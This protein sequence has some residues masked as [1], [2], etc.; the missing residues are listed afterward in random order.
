MTSDLVSSRPLRTCRFTA[1]CVWPIL[2]GVILTVAISWGISALGPP[3][4][5]TATVVVRDGGQPLVPASIGKA[6]GQRQ[7]TL[8]SDLSPP[9]ATIGAT[10]DLPHW[11]ARPNVQWDTCVSESFGWPMQALWRHRLINFSSLPPT[12]T[13][14][15]A[16]VIPRG[17]N[18]YL[19]PVGPIWTGVAVDVAFWALV[20]SAA[21]SGGRAVRR[22]LGLC[23]SCG[24]DRRGL[25]VDAKCP[26]CV[27]RVA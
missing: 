10:V 2:A 27:A 5:M 22:R 14:R 3:E 23:P 19:L 15:A 24:Y 13:S 20:A 11:V 9:P 12:E 8:A 18:R 6:L 7:W 4:F 16:I 25:A 26:E 17:Q 1:M 21:L